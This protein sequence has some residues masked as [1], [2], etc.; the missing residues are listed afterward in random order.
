MPLLC[1]ISRAGEGHRINSQALFCV[2]YGILLEFLFYFS[3]FLLIVLF[4]VFFLLSRNKDDISE[5][6]FDGV[7]I[8]VIPAPQAKFTLDEVGSIVVVDMSYTLGGG[9]GGG[10]EQSKGK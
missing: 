8:F 9:G 5:T 1:G 2:F 6:T 4:F 10:I 3:C 7:D